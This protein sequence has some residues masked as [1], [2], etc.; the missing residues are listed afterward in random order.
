MDAR[1]PD[2]RRA[3]QYSRIAARRS[4][5]RRIDAFL[6]PPAAY[7]RQVDQVFELM[8]RGMAA[9]WV[10]PAVPIRKVLPQLEKLWVEDVTQSPLYKPFVEFPR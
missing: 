9:G 5:P 8:K 3:H 1:L 10:P 4:T 2:E 6:A 7:P